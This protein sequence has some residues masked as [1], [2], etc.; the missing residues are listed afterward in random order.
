MNPLRVFL[1][2]LVGLALCGATGAS[3]DVAVPPL[4]ARVTDQTNTLTGDQMDTLEQTL[5]TF[6]SRKGTQIAVLIVP[7][8]E[9][10]TI[11]QYSMRVVEQ[12]KLGRSKADDGALL[13]VAK[14]DRTLRIEVGYGLE[15]A[16]NDAISNRII[17]EIIVPRFRKGDFYDGIS[18]GVDQ[19]IRVADGEPLPP[20]PAQTGGEPPN[21]WRFA[22]VIFVL[23]V[24]LSGA[25]R[26]AFG[27]LPGAAVAGG[28]VSLIAWL[29]AA[30]VVA[31][32]VAGAIAFLFT[33][34]GTGMGGYVGT[35]GVGRRG[36]GWGRGGRGGGF[37]GGGGGFGGGGASGRW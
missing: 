7:T 15:G 20:P 8:T 4:T 6:E 19:L 18:A 29:L 13:I 33:L 14:N 24:A 36:G 21:V 12:W 37:G 34:T 5:K 23:A 25:L 16:L 27:R 32:M 31:T 3:A 2:L 11:E 26:S 9:P 28:V 10:E 22:P 30:G 1:T 35:Y 17:Q